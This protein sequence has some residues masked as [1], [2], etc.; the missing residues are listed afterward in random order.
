[1]NMKIVAAVFIALTIIFAAAFG[2]VYALDSSALSHKNSEITSKNNQISSLKAQYDN[3]KAAAVL[4]AAYSHWNNITIENLSLVSAEYT[5]N[6]TLHWIGGPLSGTYTGISQ[7]N[8]T[9]TKFFNLWSAVWFYAEAPPTVMV[10]GNTATVTSM[11]QF[12][13]TPFSAEKQVQYLNISYTLNYILVNNNWKIYNEV[14][15]IVGSGFISYTAGEVHSLKAEAALEAAFSHWNDIAIENSSLLEPQYTSNATLHWIGGPLTGTYKG[16]TSV[17]NTWTKFFNIWSAVWF[18]TIAPPSVSVSGNTATVTSMNQF[19]LT[20]YSNQSQVQYLN[21][22]YT[23]NFVFMNNSWKIY[24]EVW[25]IVGSGFI[26]YAQEFAEYNEI[27]S[28]GLNHINQIAIENISLIMPQYAK[29]ATLYWAKGPLAG[30]Y[31][32][33]SEINTTWTKFFAMWQAVWFYAST[34]MTNNPVVTIHGNT[35]YYN[36]TFTQFIVQNSTGF[37]Y[38]NVTYSIKYYNF[39][40]NP[41]TGHDDYK[42]VYEIFDNTALGPISKLE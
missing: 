7:I 41:A 22:S 37:Y 21:I 36:A 9:W 39:G 29:N 33:Y 34:N 13:L 28:L 42:I 11:N 14:W 32:N 18:Y 1:M 16:E 24:N 31:T 6:A 10:S 40:F 26:S 25:H 3:E 5:S 4:E 27:S 15:H 35:A 17:I 19:I 23:L 2:A 30:T 20:P 8:A 12:V 38:I